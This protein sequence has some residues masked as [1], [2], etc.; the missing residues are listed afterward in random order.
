[1]KGSAVRIRA[2]ALSKRPLDL[3]DA[4]VEAAAVEEEGLYVLVRAGIDRAPEENRVVAA[5]ELLL[6][7]AGQPRDRT[8][9]H[10]DAVDEFV[11]NAGELLPT[12]GFRR[13]PARQLLLV[14]REHI[15]AEASRVA[16][17][18]ERVRRV[19]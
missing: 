19:V 12:R 16:D 15:D 13:E 5:L 7:L 4:R 8:A 6:K 11:R 14:G 17:R 18:F 2:S 9:E 1:M 3:E 10:R